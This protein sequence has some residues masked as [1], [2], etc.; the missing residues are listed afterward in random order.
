MII[1]DDKLNSTAYFEQCKIY[2]LG[3]LAILFFSMSR[4]L[5]CCINPQPGGP[6]D[7]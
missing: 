5:V 7:F 3:F 2:K 1:R 6:G 4:G